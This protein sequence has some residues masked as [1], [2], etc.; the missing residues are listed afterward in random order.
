[1]TLTKN[2]RKSKL[3]IHD[4]VHKWCEGISVLEKEKTGEIPHTHHLSSNKPS[5]PTSDPEN[6]FSFFAE[7]YHFDKVKVKHL[8]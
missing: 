2:G 4:N 6:D 5:C 7:I 1:M 8:L 3:K